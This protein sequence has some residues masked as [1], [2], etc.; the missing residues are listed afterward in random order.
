[1]PDIPESALHK[2]LDVEAWLK[3]GWMDAVIAG[4]GRQFSSYPLEKW[5]ALAHEHQVPVYGSVERMVFDKVWSRSRIPD[6]LRGAV[7]TLW[8]KGADGIY[9]F[10][11]Y[12]REEFFLLHEFADRHRLA[13]R[14]QEY[15]LDYSSKSK[16]GEPLATSLFIAEEP[17]RAEQLALRFVWKAGSDSTPPNV[18]INGQAFDDFTTTKDKVSTST[19][20]ALAKLLRRGV[21][22]FTLDAPSAGELSWLSVRLT[23]SE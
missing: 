1:V 22:E 19:S 18:Q 10:N 8:D 15:R 13:G 5:V 14:P 16:A 17:A 4:P 11:F 23:P 21:N 7:A 9:L 2:G 3:A 6:I 12:N 20:P